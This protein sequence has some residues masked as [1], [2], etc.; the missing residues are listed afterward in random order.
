M[1]EQGKKIKK[2][3]LDT[4]NKMERNEWD[5]RGEGERDELIESD[6]GRR[7]KCKWREN[8]WGREG[9]MQIMKTGR[10][11]KWVTQK[12]ISE[13]RNGWDVLT[14]EWREGKKKYRINDKRQRKG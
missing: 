7:K 9:R 8:E 5:K 1:I 11:L 12:L 14:T 4:Y 2:E 3:Q 6:K 10:T 13:E